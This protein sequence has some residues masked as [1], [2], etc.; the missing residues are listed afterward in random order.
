MLHRLSKQYTWDA[1]AIDEAYKHGVDW[2]LIRSMLN[3]NVGQLTAAERSALLVA[4]CNGYWPAAR[5][6]R[7]GYTGHGTCDACLSEVGE[8]YHCLHECGALLTEKTAQRWQGHLGRTSHSSTD[9]ALQ[10][11]MICGLPPM[12]VGLEPTEITIQEGDLAPNFD[13]ESFGDGSGMLQEHAECRIATWSVVRLGTDGETTTG[14]A[15]ARGNIGGWFPTVPRAEL[16]AYIYHMSRA[17]APG[18]YIGDCQQVVD[19]GMFGVSAHQRSAGS[20]HADLWREAYRLQQDHGP[21]LR[22]GKTKAH[23]SKSAAQT[24]VDDP[25]RWWKGNDAADEAAKSLARSLAQREQKACT[26]EDA[27]GRCA[28]TLH[29]VAF[30]AACSFGRWPSTHVAEHKRRARHSPPDKDA[31]G[32]CVRAGHVL[33]EYENRAWKCEVCN[34]RARGDQGWRSF[35]RKPCQGPPA[36]QAHPTH[37]IKILGAVTWCNACGAFAVRW[38]RS[39]RI[40]CPR[41][42]LSAAQRHVLHRLRLGMSPTAAPYLAGATDGMKGAKKVSGV[43]AAAGGRQTSIVTDVSCGRYLR[44]KGGPLYRAPRTWDRIDGHHDHQ[45]RH[46]DLEAAVDNEARDHHGEHAHEGCTAGEGVRRSADEQKVHGTVTDAAAS[47]DGTATLQDGFKPSA[48]DTIRRRIRGKQSNTSTVRTDSYGTE[49]CKADP[50]SNHPLCGADQMAPW[51]SRLRCTVLMQSA[52]CHRCARPCR[53][54]CRGCQRRLCIACAK[55]KSGCVSSTTPA[56]G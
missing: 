26:L 17:M 27:R 34:L 42:P 1:L 37:D 13:G 5:R 4:T 33:Y 21:G 29:H 25:L 49:A 3:G 40:P 22:V 18:S 11:L 44:L 35:N 14:C 36:A 16:F 23:R 43:H 32:K 20:Y 53:A 30:A 19:A 28:Q 45:L 10:P 12:A 2:P 39:L 52:P 15:V 7:A 51:S 9:A 24:S 6:W 55:E 38:P 56:V 41:H 54:Q 48:E 46:A 50:W 31:D 47:S 8:A